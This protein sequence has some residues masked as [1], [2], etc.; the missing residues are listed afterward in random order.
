MTSS[1]GVTLSCRRSKKHRFAILPICLPFDDNSRPYPVGR[2]GTFLH[3]NLWGISGHAPRQK[4]EMSH[5]FDPWDNFLVP[6]KVQRTFRRRNCTLLLLL[7]HQSES[8]VQW[9]AQAIGYIGDL[10]EK[11]KSGI[12]ESI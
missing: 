11:C 9:G 12:L 4:S 6:G 1:Q 3:P 5:G 2:F 10:G 7:T 8:L